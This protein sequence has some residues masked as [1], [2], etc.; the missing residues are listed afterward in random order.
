MMPKLAQIHEKAKS[1][2]N[3]FIVS[4]KKTNF[5]HHLVYLEHLEHQA[6]IAHIAHQEKKLMASHNDLGHWGERLAE[7]YLTKKGY[8]ICHRNWKMG[9]RDLD[10]TALSPDGDVLVIVEVK[11]RRDTEYTQPEEAVDW[12]KIRNLAAAA[13]AYI[14]RY[15]VNCDVRFDIISVVGNG[16][17]AQIE[18]IED[19]FSPPMY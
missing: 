18:H 1:S 12:R 4:E 15:Q 19:A 16:Q 14:Q 8:S 5:A 2:N 3:N 11:T 9:H 6:H 13:N 17:E 7:E 10:L